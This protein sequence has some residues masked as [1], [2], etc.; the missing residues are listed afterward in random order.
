MRRKLHKFFIENRKL[1]IKK[2]IIVD[3]FEKTNNRNKPRYT[4]TV[5]KHQ[6]PHNEMIISWDKI[7]NDATISDECDPEW[8]ETEHPLFILYTSGST[9]KPKGI[10]HTVAGYML[11]AATAF[12]HAFNYHDGDI[13][14]CTADIGWITGHTASVYGALANGA[15]S[16]IYEGI[17]TH[18]RVDR[19]WM[20]INEYKVNIFYTSPS[21]IRSL[22]KFGERYVKAHSM[23]DLRLIALVGET[24]NRQTWFWIYRYIGQ[25]RCPIVDTY[26]Q[27]ETGA[28]M[29]FT[30]PYAM[31]MKP[32]STGLPWFGVVPVI[33]DDSGKEI[34]GNDQ[35]HLVYKQAWPGMARTFDDERETFETVYFKKFP[36]YFYTGDGAFRDTDG[37]YWITGRM[38]DSMN[39]SGHL[40]SPIEVE[41]A[42]L[43]DKRV[44]EAAVVSMPHPVKGQAICAFIVLK[45]GNANLDSAFNNELLSIG[46]FSLYLNVILSFFHFSYN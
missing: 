31:D 20:I 6:S 29:I 14:F 22:M 2:I 13:F 15:T 27:T 26:F 34:V 24:V 8:V 16:V 42:L 28:P 30:I 33:L 44:A 11:S 38:D 19:F 36:G 7:I 18:P 25:E 3:R 39:V 9:G 12:K 41:N 5:Q 35:G 23:R 4:E 17:P 46:K 21:A 32:G 10:L 37:Y 45:Q 40:L 1:E 43:S